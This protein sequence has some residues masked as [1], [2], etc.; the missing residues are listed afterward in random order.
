[1]NHE[2]AAFVSGILLK[3]MD[4]FTP[5]AVIVHPKEHNMTY[6]EHCTHTLKQSYKMA[7]STFYLLIHSF[8]P[9]VWKTTAH[10]M[11]DE[12]HR[13]IQEESKNHAL[14]L[15]CP[16]STTPNTVHHANH[17]ED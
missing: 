10:A 1:M 9:F 14:I 2:N 13:E 15:R 5:D 8:V 17:D 3:C 11:I 12:V 16:Y 7:W 4:R 6:V